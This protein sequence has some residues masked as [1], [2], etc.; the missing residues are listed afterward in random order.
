[1]HY[2]RD[3]VEFRSYSDCLLLEDTM[4]SESSI[5][6]CNETRMETEDEYCENF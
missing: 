2:L 6:H 5:T 4:N 3:K 1:M